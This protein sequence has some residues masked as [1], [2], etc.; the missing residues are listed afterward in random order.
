MSDDVQAL[1]AEISMN[2][3]RVEAQ[4][5]RLLK[6]F[7]DSFGKMEKSGKQRL[8]AI[9]RQAEQMSRN[10]RRA[11]VAIGVG[12]AGREVLEYEAAW[13]NTT[14]TLKQ[15]TDVLGPAQQAASTLNQIAN[16]A[17][18]PLTEL[19]GVTGSAARSARDLG[20]A[21]GDVL[22]FSEAVAKGARL[23]N[24]GQAA[25]QGA[26]IQ[27]Q[28]AIASP[29]VQLQ[30]FNSIIE[31]TPRLAQAFA[32]GVDG[33]GGSVAKLRKMI[34]DGDVSG[35]AL[36]DGLISQAEKLKEEF[37]TLDQGPAEAVTRL[38][39]KLIEFVGTNETVKSGTKGLVTLIDLA[40]DNLD[41]LTESIIVGTAALAGFYGTQGLL[42]VAS[43]LQGVAVGATAGARAM[44]LLRAASAFLLT[45]VGIAMMAAAAAGA[46][47][48]VALN[49]AKAVDPLERLRKAQEGANEALRQT[50]VYVDRKVIA[51]IGEEAGKSVQPVNFLAGALREVAA[52]MQDATIA[53]FLQQMADLQSEI[54]ETQAAI[55]VGLAKRDRMGRQAVAS[56]GLGTQALA[57]GGKAT[58]S[59]DTSELDTEIGLAR[60]TL[61]GLERRRTDIGVSLFGDGSSKEFTDAILKGDVAAAAAVLK[62]RLQAVMSANQPSGKAVG[63][64]DPDKETLAKLDEIRKAYRDVYETEREA[65]T[66]VRDERLKAI[67]AAG[68]K[69]SEADKLR[70]QAIDVYLDQ[71]EELE[72]AQLKADN[73]EFQRLADKVQAEKDA[74]SEIQ[75]ARDETHGR[76]AALLERDYQQARE[77]AAKQITD[78][79]RLAEALAAIDEDYAERRK[80]LEDEV[81]GRGKFSS[82]EVDQ[83]RAVE[84]EKLLA[85]EEWYALNLEREQEYLDRRKAINAEAE[86][87]ITEMRME[88]ANA[89][90]EALE[91]GFRAA[92]GLA[93]VF[94]KEN[95][96]IVKAMFLADKAAALASAYVQMN[97][98]VAKAAAAAPPPANAPLITAAKVTG[99]STIAGIAASAISGFK[100]GVVDYQGK[101]GPRSDSNVV[102]ISRGE[103]VMNEPATRRNEGLLRLMNDGVDVEARLAR[104]GQSQ[105]MPAAMFAPPGRAISV[106]G[107]S[108]NF[109]GPVDSEAVPS[110]RQAL[111]ASNRDLRDMISD[112]IAQ[113]RK[114]TTPRHLRSKFFGG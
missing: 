38:R 99:L 92:T 3:R 50:E 30:E 90:L 40:A 79:T 62:G 53:Q 80:Q 106:G 87:A 12:V 68:L 10:V 71:I 55:D 51:R 42:A 82:N 4:Q 110:F 78:A 100:D 114:H 28:Q 26:F 18:A 32:D 111:D 49:A 76:M 29:R 8:T 101:G 74:L 113:D 65:I 103:S 5:R 109:Y 60:A 52:A 94:F 104:A 39:N 88:A 102:R 107:S 95:S 7:D 13:R 2:T 84:E 83:I 67:D 9:E 66:R 56:S 77:L 98:A 72:V 35:G 57:A 34:A 91:K 41:I 81:L 61:A 20:K 89:Q 44:A 24:T 97:L 31:G 22:V 36:F 43:G 105:A 93:K 47:A 11:I 17:R 108:L 21:G 45:P 112:L 86:A 63:G 73:A 48:L 46:I 6:S 70:Q 33:A 15:Y 59:V 64:G 1:I 23:A 96:G 85:L 16:D 25:V 19:A 27:L 69:Q 37:K 54:S 58:V 14:N 75:A